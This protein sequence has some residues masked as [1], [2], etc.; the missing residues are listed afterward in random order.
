MNRD[1]INAFILSLPDCPKPRRDIEG[2]FDSLQAQRW[3]KIR[4]DLEALISE[5]R[6]QES[7]KHRLKPESAPF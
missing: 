5:E 4:D 1:K 7:L 3:R 2:W 6:F